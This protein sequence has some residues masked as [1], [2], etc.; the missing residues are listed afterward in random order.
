MSIIA[1]KTKAMQMSLI[2]FIIFPHLD[3]VELKERNRSGTAIGASATPLQRERYA[4]TVRSAPGVVPGAD[5]GGLAAVFDVEDITQSD[6]SDP[7]LIISRIL[8]HDD[9]TATSNNYL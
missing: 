9:T 2:R 4:N 1:P 8:M 6:G 7:P 5:Y 3:L